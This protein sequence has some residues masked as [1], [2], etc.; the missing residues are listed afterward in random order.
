MVSHVHLFTSG[1]EPL[2]PL[3]L[4]VA[5]VPAL[6]KRL[7]QSV[8]QSCPALVSL[9]LTGSGQHQMTLPWTSLMR[10]GAVARRWQAEL[11]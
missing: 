11:V 2:Q 5:F 6:D 3:Q 4:G 7:L 8:A 1:V 10:G 9:D